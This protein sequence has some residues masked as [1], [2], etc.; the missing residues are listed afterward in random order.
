M[1]KITK[2][3]ADLSTEAQKFL[4]QLAR[5]TIRLAFEETKNEQKEEETTIP[6]EVQRLG[7][8]FV[9]LHKKTGELRGCIGTFDTTQKLWH[10]VRSMA[11]AAAF[12]DPRFV[13]LTL[14]ELGECHLEIS[15][16]TPPVQAKAEDV[17]PGEHGLCIAKG[18]FR[19]VLLPQVASDYGWNR[20]EFLAHTCQKARLPADAWRDPSTLIEVFTAQVFGE[21]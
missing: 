16:L 6:A 3:A 21:E 8:C 5:E 15:A 17:V 18:H 13:S 7:G 1:S 14:E 9:T 10:S 12:E 11:R 20:E 4:L 2:S 19:G